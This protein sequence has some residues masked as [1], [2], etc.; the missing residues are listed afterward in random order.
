MR[1]VGGVAEAGERGEYAC[2][3]VF[4]WGELWGAVFGDGG[5][6]E[7]WWAGGGYGGRAYVGGGDSQ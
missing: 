3:G 7:G 5:V 6:D 1:G 4:G 2:G